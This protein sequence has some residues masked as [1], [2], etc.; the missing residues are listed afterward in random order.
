[1]CVAGEMGALWNML[2]WVQILDIFHARTK[3]SQ[4]R[5]VIDHGN[6]TLEIMKIF[7]EPII[8]AI[9]QSILTGANGL[10]TYHV[11]LKLKI[12]TLPL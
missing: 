8:Q 6:W 4:V 1:M 7:L 12:L 2:N 5:D 3:A 11:L 10:S 9:N